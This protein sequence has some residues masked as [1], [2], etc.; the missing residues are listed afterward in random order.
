VAEKVVGGKCP[1]VGGR[2]SPKARKGEAHSKGV[3][4]GQQAESRASRHAISSYTKDSLSA[5]TNGGERK[6]RVGRLRKRRT[7]EERK[8]GEDKEGTRNLLVE[9][10][11]AAV[12]SNN[13]REAGGTTCARKMKRVQTITCEEIAGGSGYRL[14]NYHD[15]GLEGEVRKRKIRAPRNG[16]GGAGGGCN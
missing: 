11:G 13:P 10:P 14:A 3:R 2:D 4:L 1:E 15:L 12:L 7:R 16:E 8:R 9:P 5:K 6:L